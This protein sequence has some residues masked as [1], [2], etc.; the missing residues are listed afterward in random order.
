MIQ[1]NVDKLEIE[2]T[3]TSSSSNAQFLKTYTFLGNKRC[4]NSASF[5]DQTATNTGHL[6]DTLRSDRSGKYGTNEF[7]EDI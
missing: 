4:A 1:M 6:I 3:Q 7:V 5:A 2:K